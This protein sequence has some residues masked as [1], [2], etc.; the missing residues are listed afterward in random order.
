MSK[1]EQGYNGYSNYET[2]VV[3]LWL[4][5]SEGDY[6]YWREAAEEAISQAGDDAEDNSEDTDKEPTPEEIKAVLDNAAYHLALRLEEELVANAE[7]VPQGNM[8]ADLL[9]RAL[10]RVDWQEIASAMV[11]DAKEE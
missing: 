8:Y 3:K 11:E 5:N 7:G 9:G 2:W 10:G 1:D 4:D 6:N